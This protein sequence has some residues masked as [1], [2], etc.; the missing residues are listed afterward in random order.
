M[1]TVDHYRERLVDT[2]LPRLLASL[3]AVL[4]VGPRATGKT[5]T[6]QR[7][8]ETVVR[9]DQ[10]TQ[11]A[12]FMADPDS[13]LAGMA[14][15]VLLDEWQCVPGVLGAVKRAVDDAH[16]PGRFILTGSVRN[17]GT[18]PGTGRLIWLDMHPLTVSELLGTS[19]KPL[20]ERLADGDPLEPAPGTPD[21]RG[22]IDLAL[23]SGFPEIALGAPEPMRR[24]W[25]R[26]YIRQVVERDALEIDARRDPTRLGR[27]FEAYALNSAGLAQDRT[28][29]TAAGINRETALAYHQLLSNLRVIDELP[30]WRSN[31]LAR[32]VKA[33]KRYVVDPALLAAVTGA[34]TSTVIADG[35]L[36]GRT[37]ETFVVAQ[38]RAEAAVSELYPRLHH[39]RDAQGRHEVDVVAELDGRRIVAIEV[40]ATGAPGPTHGR[41]LSWLRDQL[42]DRFVH[43][44]VL[45]TGPRSFTLGERITAAPI[46]VL[47]A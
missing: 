23:R 24:R 17:V 36:L 31:R 22:Y 9:L 11:A 15:P 28:I 16:R 35:D 21:L 40:K 3:P 46:S 7:Y 14:E 1:S 39:L 8:A 19:T 5:T 29:H 45:H 32:L 2:L 25:L 6:A 44:L 26:S 13:A 47:W 4:M 18:W 43:G 10:D 42:G 41:H 38:L 12:A 27:Y 34:T 33:P 30:A 20:L 37:I